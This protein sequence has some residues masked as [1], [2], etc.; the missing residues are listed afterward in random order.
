MVA[1]IV[2]VMSPI[3]RWIWASLACVM[4]LTVGC[5]KEAKLDRHIVRADKFFNEGKYPEL[6][7]IHI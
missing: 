2:D 6:S 1:I 4:L 7:L 3:F 5:S